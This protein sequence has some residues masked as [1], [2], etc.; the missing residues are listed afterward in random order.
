MCYELMYLLP[1][2]RKILIGGNLIPP[3]YIAW[4]QTPRGRTRTPVYKSPSPTTPPPPP[5]IPQRVIDK[6]EYND[7]LYLNTVKFFR[8]IKK[9]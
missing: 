6:I 3:E 2:R 9:I 7:F 1:I 4:N 8:S 5:P